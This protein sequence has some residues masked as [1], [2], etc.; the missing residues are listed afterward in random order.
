M[1]E[2]HLVRFIV[3]RE[4]VDETTFAVVTAR[5]EDERLIDKG[6]FY[7]ALAAACKKWAMTTDDGRKAAEETSGDFNVGDLAGAPL[8][9]GESL[10]RLL[11]E[12]DIHELAIELHTD[13]D[14]A[15]WE[16]DDQLMT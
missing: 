12:Q 11:A 8:G 13:G 4:S 3:G 6:S 1:P 14:T 9:P 16:Y 10:G 7:R 2:Q 15:A 5:V